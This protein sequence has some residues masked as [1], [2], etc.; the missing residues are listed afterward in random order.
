MMSGD[1]AAWFNLLVEALNKGEL[2]RVQ[3]RLDDQNHTFHE[4]GYRPHFD[5]CIDANE[6]QKFCKKLSLS[7]TFLS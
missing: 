7:A 5:T 6:L 4:V 1:A 2:Q 3:T